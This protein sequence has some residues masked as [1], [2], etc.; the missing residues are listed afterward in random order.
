MGAG[1]EF[2]VYSSYQ[3]SRGN[4]GSRGGGTEELGLAELT[5]FRVQLSVWKV[6]CCEL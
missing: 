5:V 6:L 1:R 2:E 4:G 3:A